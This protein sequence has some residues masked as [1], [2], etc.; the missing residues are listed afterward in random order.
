MRSLFVAR[1]GPN[2]EHG[3]SI[4]RRGV[5][6]PAVFVPNP[7]RLRSARLG[8]LV[9]VCAAIALLVAMAAPSHADAARVQCTGTFLSLIHI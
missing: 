4:G 3:H 9:A 8:G 2:R 7:T 6:M 1:T 5:R